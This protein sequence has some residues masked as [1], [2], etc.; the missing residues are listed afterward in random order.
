[1][2]MYLSYLRVYFKVLS[3]FQSNLKWKGR[4]IKITEKLVDCANI[5]TLNLLLTQRFYATVDKF[6][7]ICTKGHVC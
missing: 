2:Y 4:S 5:P 6:T 7:A 3:V 1:M